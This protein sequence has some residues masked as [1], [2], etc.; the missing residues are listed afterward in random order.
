MIKQESSATCVYRIDYSVYCFSC[1][2]VHDSSFG[3]LPCDFLSKLHKEKKLGTVGS[4]IQQF[5]G[6]LGT[7]W[8]H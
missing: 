4:L 1:D 3:D 5:P 2:Q 6:T 8:F 7:G